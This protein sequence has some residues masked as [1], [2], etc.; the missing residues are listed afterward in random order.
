MTPETDDWHQLHPVTILREMA[1]VGWAVVGVF[2]FDFGWD[3]QIDFAPWL[4]D[5]SDLFE[6]LFA[7]GAFGLAVARYFSTRFRVTDT[8]VEFRRGVLYRTERTTRRDRIQNVAVGTGLLGRIFG[9]RAVEISAG[10][11]ADIAL[12]YVG[13]DTAASLR[14]DLLPSARTPDT[15]PTTARETRPDDAVRVIARLDRHGFL[16][17]LMTGPVIGAIALVLVVVGA[18]VTLEERWPLVGSAGLFY[19]FARSAD[20]YHFRAA[21]TK[22]RLHVSHGLIRREEKSAELDR[23]QTIQIVR[24]VIRGLLG[25]ETVRLQTADIT[26]DASESM[27]VNLLSPLET[28]GRGL[29]ITDEIL[30]GIH[31]AEEDLETAA[32]VAFRRGMVR[33]LFVMVAA[34]LLLGGG[35]SL[36]RSWIGSPVEGGHLLL[37][38][39]GYLVVSVLV[40]LAFGLRR[41]RLLGHALGPDHVLISTGVFRH[42]VAVVP[43]AKIQ[44][45]RIRSTFLQRNHDIVDVAI[46]TAGMSLVGIA[47]TTVFDVSTP[48]GTE[49]AD[50]LCHG[51]S[52]VALPDGV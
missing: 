8:A 27:Q 42:R 22:D 17:Y 1:S 28:R 6:I 45:I 49:L 2:V 36:I 20:V 38:G 15:S 31:V 3:I 29:A 48:V 30:G 47:A 11:L 16:R 14:T 23:I 34:G 26:R 50:R 40:A 44:S 46:D 10:D 25:Y 9:V 7:V 41:Y 35:F 51:A 52:A 13:R 37:F 24:P 43:I 19:L 4:P 39:G 5:G 32:S 33:A 12:T 18:F 21:T